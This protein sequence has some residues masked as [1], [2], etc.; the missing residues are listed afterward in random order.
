M[1]SKHL[2]NLSINIDKVLEAEKDILLM[3]IAI[4]TIDD[5]E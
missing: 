4:K 1:R 3:N 2:E 5:S